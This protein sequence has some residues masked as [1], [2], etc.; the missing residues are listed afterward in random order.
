MINA[1]ILA[2][3]DK[4][5]SGTPYECKALIKIG[6]KYLIEYVLDAVCSSK[7]ISRRVVVGP[8]QLK[9]FLISMYPQVEFVEEDTSIMKN[10][11]KA[12]EFLNDDKKILFLTAD[13]PF[14]TAEAID[15]FIEESIKSGA[16]ICYPI[17]EKSI[18]DE[19]YPQMKRTYGTVKEGT[20]TGGNAI[21]ITPSVFE[22]CYSLA[23]KLVEKRK[24]PIAMARLIGPTILLLFLTKR[25]SIQKVE[26]RVSKVFKVKAKAIIS[27][28]P[29]LGQDVD[30]DSDLMVA[31]FYLE[32]K[33]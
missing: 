12:I 3:S 2:G 25:L 7:H 11:K 26:K 32:K 31:K 20:F 28:Y 1:V 13:L 14:I 21:I 23:E 29:E 6:E 10:A 33:M 19:K 24:N 9:E 16:D 4:N 22:K 5:K 17:V 27:T 18:N 30:K 15:H 8:V